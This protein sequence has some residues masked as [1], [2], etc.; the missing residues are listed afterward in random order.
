[1]PDHNTANLRYLCACYCDI[2]CYK[3]GINCDTAIKFVSERVKC[4][5]LPAPSAIVRSGRG[6]WLFWLLHD[7]ADKSRAHLGAYPD[8]LRN[9]LQ[10]Y[11]RINREIGRRLAELGADPV[12][13]DA[14][15]Y[16]RVPGSFRNDVE[17]EVL[18]QWED[19]S[20]EMVLSYSLLDLGERLGVNKTTARKPAAQTEP[21]GK[22]PLRRHGFIAANANK[23]AAFQSLQGLRGGFAEGKRSIAAFI[24]AVS[25]KW[26]GRSRTEATRE[27][28][29]FGRICRPPFPQAE[30][31]SAVKSAYK[32]KG[33]TMRYCWIADQLDVTLAEAS[34]ISQ[35]IGK[36]FPAAARFGGQPAVAA[37]RTISARS[38]AL[39]L[40]RIEIRRVVEE[41]GY[42]PS[43]RALRDML[44]FAGV[45][46]GHVTVMADLRALGLI[47]DSATR[48]HSSLSPATLLESESLF[49][50]STQEAGF[51]SLIA[52]ESEQG[53]GTSSSGGDCFPN[54][55]M[56]ATAA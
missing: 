30:C 5:D 42:V 44:L 10:L 33:T 50:S 6:L 23:L 4:G 26:A 40:R 54:H 35:I 9:H 53:A 29:E 41:R 47:D 49:P 17:E 7:E 39:I 45:S 31:H 24:F 15:R 51:T 22:H 25:L 1:M 43:S 27:L 11:A 52:I 20:G 32:K 8:N 14:A 21:A 12:A 2:D 38:T 3:I 28:E 34:C 46:V 16:V 37:P 19:P 36:P 18:W 56:Q 13:T 55:M 48:Q